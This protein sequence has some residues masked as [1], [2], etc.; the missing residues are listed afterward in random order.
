M[1]PPLTQAGSP[2]RTFVK[3]LCEEY[4]RLYHLALLEDA[5]AQGQFGG[6][7]EK[8]KK[9]EVNNRKHYTK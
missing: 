8:E 7:E 5:R 2:G 1:V 6:E 4:L 9:R 3:C